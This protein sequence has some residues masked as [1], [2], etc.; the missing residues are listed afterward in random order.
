MFKEWQLMTA[1]A[2]GSVLLPL[3]PT[4]SPDPDPDYS[5]TTIKQ[6]EPRRMEQFQ[7]NFTFC[8]NNFQFIL[9]SVFFSQKFVT[10]DLLLILPH[11][12]ILGSL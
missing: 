7:P 5:I 8:G 6:L 1:R 4:L 12:K 9:V 3:S 2:A 11:T 10:F